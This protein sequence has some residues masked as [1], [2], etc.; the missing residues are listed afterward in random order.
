MSGIDALNKLTA[1]YQQLGKVVHLKHL[2][3]DCRRLLANA[4]SLI[5][6]NVMEDPDYLVLVDE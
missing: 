1:N 5:E 3:A 6:V 2:S 4:S